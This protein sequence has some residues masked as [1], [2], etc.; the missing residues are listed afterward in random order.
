[1]KIVEA[2]RRVTKMRVA[3]F[4][5]W[6]TSALFF[7]TGMLKAEYAALDA[8]S[9]AAVQLM[10]KLN[11]IIRNGI[12]WLYVHTQFLSLVWTFAPAPDFQE[13]NTPGNYWILLWMSVAV[14][15]GSIRN[16]ASRLARR[17]K[18]RIERVEELGWERDLLAQQGQF[19]GQKP[20]VLQI[21]IDLDQKDQW[22]KRPVGL[23]AIGIAIAVLGQIVNLTFGLAH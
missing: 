10:P 2:Q 3:S 23:I 1:M 6:I 21:N 14:L 15:A 8:A 11:D 20:D 18:S 13:L 17:I 7:V 5:M 19:I 12:E 4:V 9:Q 16:A 22:Y